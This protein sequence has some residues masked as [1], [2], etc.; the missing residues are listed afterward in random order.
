M[1][2]A[3]R[4]RLTVFEAV[5]FLMVLAIGWAALRAFRMARQVEN[6]P[7]TFQQ[8]PDGYIRI[9]N[10]IEP[11]VN[12]LNEILARFAA[13]RERAD[14][15]R[16]QR[17][18]QDV[19]K[20]IA[21]EKN[22]SIKTKV[23][24]LQPV[25]VTTDISSLL[26]QIDVAFDAYVSEAW[27]A[28]NNGAPGDPANPTPVNLE[29]VRLQS[30]QLLALAN[31][32]RAQGQAIQI[33]LSGSKSWFPWLKQVLIGSLLILVAIGL[34]LTILVYRRVVS[35]LRQKLVE[36]DTIIERQQKLAHFGELAAGVAHE[37]RNPLTA[38]RARLFTLQKTLAAGTPAHEDTVVIR[39]EIDRLN[40]IVTDFLQL[41]RPAEPRVVPVA[42][43]PLLSEVRQLFVPQCEKQRIE[44]KVETTDGARL[45]ADPQQMK[46]VLINLI[47]NAADSIEMDG[48]ITLRARP[49]KALLAK[50]ACNTVVIEVEDTGP[51]IPPAVQRRLFDP[52]FST[53][54]GGTGLGL[55]IAAQIVNN[56]GGKLEFQTQ[57]S[58]GTRFAI[59]LP[60]APA[61]T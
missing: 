39:N 26:D 30:R 21:E 48:K 43:E 47:Q 8:M 41:A 54:E 22:S 53:K 13:H 10:Q 36:S 38:I 12:N 32:A 56:H 11:S 19:K 46:Q 42:A 61:P 51:G 60:A 59:V 40:R 58:A 7:V 25:Q 17:Q 6:I 5:L 45:L 9:A 50:N 16:F 23:T 24:M 34:W 4:F 49:D 52:F 2:S 57:S 55:S 18:S 27:K 33:F 35:P 29:K 15:D 14:W 44:L 1:S 28:T 37:I 31:Q 20:W 3:S